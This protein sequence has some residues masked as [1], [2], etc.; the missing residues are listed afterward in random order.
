MYS[1]SIS[2]ERNQRDKKKQKKG[3]TLLVMEVMVQE[4]VEFNY[5]MNKRKLES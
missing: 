1:L 5:R 3:V 2:R 4:N